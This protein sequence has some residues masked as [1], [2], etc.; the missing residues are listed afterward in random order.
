MMSAQQF[1]SLPSQG[2]TQ[3]HETLGIRLS[4]AIFFFCSFLLLVIAAC[5]VTLKSE[6]VWFHVDPVSVPMIKI[7]LKSSLCNVFG[8]I[9]TVWAMFQNQ[10]LKKKFGQGW[11]KEWIDK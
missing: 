3:V 5:Q 2:N 7:I 10:V 1:L 8:H 11:T 6:V 4:E 9:K